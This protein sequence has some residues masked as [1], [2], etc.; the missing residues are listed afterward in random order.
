MKT[1]TADLYD[2]Y[3]AGFDNA[4]QFGYMPELEDKFQALA[5]TDGFKD[6]KI[7]LRKDAT[8]FYT[9]FIFIY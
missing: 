8:M 2:I 5:Y 4:I 1:S 6:G 9:N 7:G 3:T